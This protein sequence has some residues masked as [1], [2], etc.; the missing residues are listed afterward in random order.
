MES[1]WHTPEESYDRAVD[2]HI[3]TIRAKLKSINATVSP[4][5]TH[6]GVGYSI[7]VQG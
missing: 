2:T 6:R 1:V 7:K 3:K 5:I 4:I